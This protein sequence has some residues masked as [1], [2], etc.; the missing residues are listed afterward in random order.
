MANPILKWAGGK[1][2]L[3]DRIL[4]L[5]PRNY[6]SL[7]YHEPF[8]GGGAVFFKIRPKVG[9][10]NDINPRLMNLYK[11]VRDSPN[12]LMSLART[13][14]HDKDEFY[15]LREQ[16]N[17]P[18]ISN[19][20]DAALLLYLNKTAFNGLYRVN[21]KGIFNVPFGRYKNPTIVDEK[22][23]LE[24]SDLF[25]HI[26]LLCTDFTYIEEV[27]EKGDLVYFDPPYL[28]V[29][30]T[31]RFTTYAKGGFSYD[32]QIRLRDSCLKLDEK[33]VHFVLS[34][35]YVKPLLEKYEEIDTFLVYTVQANRAINSKGSA[36][37]PIKEILVTNISDEDRDRSRS[38][39]DFFIER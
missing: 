15:K 35:S 4:L 20:E 26:D 16:F 21:S 27:S 23:I 10:I 19:I 9:T 24:A 36:R 7:R 6:R 38:T 18:D 32:D 12:E 8:I 2:Q 17:Q 13:Y 5:F 28:P 1:R 22:R 11:V 3:L 39:M 31:A 25:K 29:S 37:G 34:N 14:V 33:G 30:D